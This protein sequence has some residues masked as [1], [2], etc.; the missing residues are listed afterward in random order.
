MGLHIIIHAHDE[1]TVRIVERCHKGI[2]L[3]EIFGQVN[4]F[5]EGIFFCQTAENIPG[6]ILGIIID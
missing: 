5:D 1:I 2:V 6:I 4:G 3:T